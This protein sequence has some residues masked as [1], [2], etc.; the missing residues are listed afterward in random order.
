M[1]SDVVMLN[2]RARSSL[3]PADQATLLAEATEAMAPGHRGAIVV[4][5]PSGLTARMYCRRVG[6]GDRSSGV[7][8]HVMLDH[9]TSEQSAT[10]KAP[11]RIP[12]PSLVGASSTWLHACEEVENVFLSG[13]WL[14]VEGESGVG[15]L[16][17]LRAVQ[18]RRQPVGRFLVFEARDAPGQPHWMQTLRDALLGDSDTVVIRH[19]D[20][21]D[22]PSLRGVSSALQDA[23]AEGPNP[24]WV[25]VTLQAPRNSKKLVQLLQLFPSTIELPPLRLHLE[26]LAQ[27]VP[28]FL[29]RLSQGAHLTCSPEAMRLLMRMSW[30]GNTEQLHDVLSEV[31]KHRRTGRVEP[32]D[33][34]P[35]V[36]AVSRRVLSRLEALE[37]DA[38]VKS[39]A[40]ANGN[41]AQAA[42]SLGMSRATIYRK[43]HDF[44]IVAPTD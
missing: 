6:G 34:P 5:L 9:S 4:E 23:R 18:L 13:E 11:P 39:L 40:D 22:G 21:L 19:V 28:V 16:A 12:L 42:R 27:L 10:R 14:A 25:A 44:G 17:V 43:I 33:L 20:A 2:D 30:P 8:A 15:K 7:V 32:G 35:E 29:S 3:A 38:I 31:V 41:K 36:H 1:N 37:R 26:D 24:V